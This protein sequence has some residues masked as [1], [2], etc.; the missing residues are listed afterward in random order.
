MRKIVGI[1]KGSLKKNLK[2]KRHCDIHLNFQSF[3]FLPK[4]G[5]PLELPFRETVFFSSECL[6]KA[7]SRSL[8]KHQ[9]WS[10][11]VGKHPGSNRKIF[12]Y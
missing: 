8:P 12:Q 4:F 11:M 10:E 7:V 3:S 5:K 1:C 2:T 9:K 6:F